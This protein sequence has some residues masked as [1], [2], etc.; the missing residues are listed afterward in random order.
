MADEPI[1][2]SVVAGSTEA[3]IDITNAEV[4][5][6]NERDALPSPEK[7][8]VT[9]AQFDK[10]YNSE[11]SEYNWQAHAK[12]SEFVAG[13]RAENQTIDAESETANAEA[14]E[15]A[16]QAV[17]Q[18]GL[19]WD[20]LSRKIGETGNIDESDYEAL[21]K[22]GVPKEIVEQHV[23]MV[24]TQ[25]QDHIAKVTDAFGGQEQWQ[26]TQAWADRNLDQTEIDQLNGMLGG[27]NYEMAVNLLM[28]KA[29]TQMN[30]MPMG[31]GGNPAVEGYASQMEM[32][33]DQRN[34]EYKR[35]PAFREKV[36]QRAAASNWATSN[37]TAR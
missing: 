25:V 18:A 12:E 3:H 4:E 17:E 27:P 16:A 15:T 22:M 13:Q 34:P 11:T 24:S 6:Q 33:A 7:M 19:D 1:N 32:V 31:G 14:V 2:A 10:Y 20:V 23:N 26:Q 28:Q 8:G 21:S 29:G 9:Q 36:M 30:A 35:D 37:Y 5:I